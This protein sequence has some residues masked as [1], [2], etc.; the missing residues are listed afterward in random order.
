MA[1]AFFAAMFWLLLQQ[2]NAFNSRI[3]DFARFSQ[4]IW[5]VLDGQFLYTPIPG[6]SIMGDHFSPIMVIAAPFLLIW[7]DERVLFIVQCINITATG[8][9][10]YAIMREE[11]PAVAPWFL[12]AFFLNPAVHDFMLADFRRIFFGLPWMALAMLGLARKDRRLLLIGF[13]IAL[14]AKE[15]V[16]LYIAMIGLYLIVTE[17]DWRWGTGLFVFG[18]VA[19]FVL[20]D[21]VIP[22]F[23][24]AE[25]YPQLFYYAHLGDSY[26]EI[27]R[28]I[29]TRPFWFIQQ[30]L[31]PDQLF[32]IFRILLP[33]GFLCLLAPRLTLVCA[34]FAL[35]MFMSGRIGPIRLEEHYSA[36][37]TPILFTA[38]VIGIRQLDVKWDK[39]ISGWLTLSVIVGYIFFSHAPFG[40]YYKPDRFAVDDHDRAGN[41]ITKRVPEEISML[42]HTMY[43]PHLTHVNDLS[44][45]LDE[46]QGTPF[47]ADRIE[48]AEHIFIDRTRSQA[49]LGQFETE[50]VVKN[51]LADPNQK[52]I[53]EIDGIFFFQAVP[54]DH[55][56]TMAQAAFG[57]T[58][59]LEKV[60]VAQMGADGFYVPLEPPYQVDAGATLRVSLFWESLAEDVGERTTSTRLLAFDGF[61]LTQSDQIPA[62]GTRPTAFWSLGEQVRD[63]SYL[64]VP[65][66]R[67][68][69]NMTLDVVVYDTFSL[70]VQ[71]SDFTG[72]PL[73]IK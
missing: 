10:L 18:M 48:A 28:T 38:I 9:I 22:A 17:R 11:R 61:L 30:V 66:D 2:H 70:D 65:A 67:A 49:N 59:W 29:V 21:I 35:L 64:V 39:W 46:H 41:A 13:L 50:N 72:I 43:T 6:R 52:I 60:E 58:M 36:S 27:V 56:A 69:Q 19:L 55:A 68:G 12:L 33:L 31:G 23:G 3:G 42:A 53:E 45:F 1:A 32:G 37:M 57:E 15:T 63:V 44:V 54:S 71:R 8:L 34:P 26:G 7:P 5:S 4:A 62:E 14:L 24:G 16:A 25:A 73:E 51:L 47:S 40:G 20:S